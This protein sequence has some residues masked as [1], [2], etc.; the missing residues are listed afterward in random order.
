MFYSSCFVYFIIFVSAI[1]HFWV[2]GFTF[3][4]SYCHVAPYVHYIDHMKLVF[5]YLHTS[6][7]VLKESWCQ[8]VLYLHSSRICLLWLVM[9]LSLCSD[10][11][12]PFPSYSH[13]ESQWRAERYTHHV[14]FVVPVT[15]QMSPGKTA[16]IPTWLFPSDFSN[17]VW[18]SRASIENSFRE[19]GESAAS[20]PLW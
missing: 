20:V 15:S 13:R 14:L 18:N 16:S 5:F 19:P 1:F 17:G 12:R 6:F 10:S 4:G 9:K 7:V 8:D 2:F 11:R 3:K